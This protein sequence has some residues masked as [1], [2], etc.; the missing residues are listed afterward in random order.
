MKR[1]TGIKY[2]FYHSSIDEGIILKEYLP[3]I[4]LYQLIDYNYYF[5]D[6]QLCRDIFTVETIKLKFH[7][8]RE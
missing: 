6:E 8:Y 2:N 4:A 1:C 5:M 3:L 7:S